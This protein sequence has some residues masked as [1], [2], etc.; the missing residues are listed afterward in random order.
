MEAEAL[1][2]A[3]EA[4]VVAAGLGVEVVLARVAEVALGVSGP[5]GV[6]VRV[7]LGRVVWGQAAWGQ[8]PRTYIDHWRELNRHTGS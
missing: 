6:S 8:H 7:V 2:V 5:V 1:A 4:V 3:A